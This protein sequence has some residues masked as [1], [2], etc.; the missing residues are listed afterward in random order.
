MSD[1]RTA[2]MHSKMAKQANEIARLL[3]AVEK[4]TGEKVE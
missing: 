2:A 1:K 3:K 4:V